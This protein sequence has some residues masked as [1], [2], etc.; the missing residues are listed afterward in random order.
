LNNFVGIAALENG[1]LYRRVADPD[2]AHFE[3]GK[4]DFFAAKKT[5]DF[6]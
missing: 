5:K 4:N 6:S 2:P 3:T 1:T